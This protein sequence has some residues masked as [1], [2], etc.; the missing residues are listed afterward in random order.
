MSKHT[1]QVIRPLSGT[2]ERITTTLD[3]V[4]LSNGSRPPIPVPD[5]EGVKVNIRHELE[6]ITGGPFEIKVGFE[7]KDLTEILKECEV[8]LQDVAFSIFVRSR[9]LGTG[10]LAYSKA[11]DEVQQDLDSDSNELVVNLRN[12]ENPNECPIRSTSEGFEI[13]TV[14]T[15]ARTL[16]RKPGTLDPYRKHAIL[17][18]R[19]IDF[20]PRVEGGNDYEIKPLTKDIR[21]EKGIGSEAWIWVEIDKEALFDADKKEFGQLIETYVD[22]RVRSH[23]RT[24]PNS[25]LSKL[26]IQ[27]TFV[28]IINQFVMNVSDSLKENDYEWED[29]ADRLVGVF[30]S[31]LASSLRASDELNHKERL[32]AAIKD[33]PEKVVQKLQQ[34]VDIPA[35]FEL[36]TQE[37]LTQEEVE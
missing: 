18:S 20:S 4:S 30:C 36:L 26:M 15:L 8:M 28:Q 19:V 35:T 27:Q 10:H 31:G 33:S 32:F 2:F 13:H 25:P 23:I 1:S 3:V 12:Q 21:R 14:L 6:K 16:K 7:W 34:I 11:L 22:E 17:A 37:E 9:R 5:K 29:L 24:S